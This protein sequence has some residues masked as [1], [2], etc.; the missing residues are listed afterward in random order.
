MT[1][2]NY[3]KTRSRARL[4]FTLV[5]LLV[6]IAIIAALAA[7][8]FPVLNAMRYKAG[9]T[10]TVSNMRQV[11]IANEHYSMENHGRVMGSGKHTMEEFGR[12]DE[13][14]HVWRVA[15]YMGAQNSGP[16]GQITF[17][18]VVAIIQP[19]YH[20][21]IP[22]RLSNHPEYIRWSVAVN[23]EFLN[24]GDGFPR[25]NQYD[26]TNTIY[27]VSGYINVRH[28]QVDDPSYL[29]LPGSPREGPYFTKKKQ[30]PCLYLDGRVVLENFPID[31][32]KVNPSLQE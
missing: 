29:E 21:H 15:A 11:G 8:A 3:G 18:D 10:Q 17:A 14:H 23:I 13:L 32:A 31:P 2:M 7:I 1:L 5:E 26:A 30:L 19:L 9:V 25:M 20:P 16:R 24:R 27:C 4:G 12:D 28:T 6:V 22:K